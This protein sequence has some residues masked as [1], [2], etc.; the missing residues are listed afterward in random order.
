M[1]EFLSNWWPL[2]AASAV[3]VGGALAPLLRTF[4]ERLVGFQFDRRMEDLRYDVRIREQAAKTAE[5]L[6]LAWQL[7]ADEDKQTYRRA[8]QLGWELALYLPPDVYRHVCAAIATPGDDQNVLTALLAVRQ[9]LL[10]K[11]TGDL[12]ADELL[13]HA[14][15][16]RALLDT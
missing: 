15:N 4:L 12:V 11:Q 2:I 1:T 5:Y 7:G 8:N 16:A 6:S 13:L 10:G 9:H 3:A 14:P